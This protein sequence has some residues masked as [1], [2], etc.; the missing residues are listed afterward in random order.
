ME[1]DRPGRRDAEMPSAV[2]PPALP[3]VFTQ[4]GRAAADII[5]PDGL[6]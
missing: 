2:R 4:S 3:C 5:T 6:H 1:E